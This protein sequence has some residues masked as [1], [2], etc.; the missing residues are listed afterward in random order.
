VAT[1]NSKPYLSEELALQM[2]QAALEK[3][4]ELSIHI[5]V[6]IVDDGGNLKVFVR[7][8]RAPLL[9]SR[10]SQD[11][12]YTAASFNRPTREWYPRMEANPQ[13]LHGLNKLDRMNILTGGL[14]IRHEGHL[15]GGIGV[16]GGTGEQ[17][18]LCSQ[19]G[20]DRLNELLGQ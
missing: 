13:L 9:S 19:A 14:P 10:V 6:A 2:A 5:A 3:A 18:E 12:A 4:R 20:I 7:M 8:D 11:K 16:S 17:D 15:I 1:L